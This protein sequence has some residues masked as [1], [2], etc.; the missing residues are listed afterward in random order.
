MAISRV[1]YAAQTVVL[2]TQTAT[3]IIPCQSANADET[4][5]V[6]DVLVLGKLG[7]AGRLQKDVA[8]CKASIKGYICTSVTTANLSNNAFKN[9]DDTLLNAMLAEIRIDSIAGDAL[10]VALQYNGLTSGG[11][12]FKG[13]CS[14]IGMDIS[15]GNFGMIDLSFDGVGQI[16]DLD[17]GNPSASPIPNQATNALK[18]HVTEATPT[19]SSDVIL[20]ADGHDDDTIANLKFSFDMPTETLSRLGGTFIGDTTT[21]EGDNVTFS[22]PPFKSSMTV[23]GQS[24]VNMDADA[25]TNSS[26]N[27]VRGFDIGGLGVELVSPAVSAR[28]M[29]QAVGD[30]GATFSLTIDGTD[31]YFANPQAISTGPAAVHGDIKDV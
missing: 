20:P 8:S 24:A 1:L 7:A 29:S 17:L 31:A 28:S 30:V 5:P 26:T 18:N 22:K 16:N 15:K 6:D 25:T 13:A 3:Y 11:F 19:V 23:D 4:I 9:A 12:S 27:K 2:T 14:S 21:V 10:T